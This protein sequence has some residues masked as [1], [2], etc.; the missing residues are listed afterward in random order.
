M[1]G[2]RRESTISDNNNDRDSLIDD[3]NW[4][5]PS[6]AK[7]YSKMRL[8]DSITVYYRFESHFVFFNVVLSFDNLGARVPKRLPSLFYCFVDLLDIWEK[9]DDELEEDSD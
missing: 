7:G 1:Y 5:T 8:T 2:L 3:R 9:I 6:H 4:I